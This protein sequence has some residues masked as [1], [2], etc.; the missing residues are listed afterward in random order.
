MA[1]NAQST[2]NP[3]TSGAFIYTVKVTIPTVQVLTLNSVPVILVSAPASG[4]A[5]QLI[6]AVCRIAAYG[7]IAYTTNTSLQILTDTAT[8]SQGVDNNLLTTTSTTIR[9][10]TSQAGANL[11]AAKAL[12]A[13]VATGNPVAGNSDIIIYVTYRIITL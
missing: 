1:D 7:G 12:V 3:V 13:N 2:G 9:S 8:V 11:I 6:N 10:I 5:I 4:Y